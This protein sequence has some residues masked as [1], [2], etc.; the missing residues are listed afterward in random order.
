MLDMMIRNNALLARATTAAIIVWISWLLASGVLFYLEFGSTG[1]LAEAGARN[2]THLPTQPKPHVELSLLNLF[3][4]TLTESASTPVIDAPATRLNLELLGIFKA[5][6][7][8]QSAAIIARKGAEGE[9]FHPG[10]TL[11]GNAE[12]FDVLNDHVLIKR[13]GN[14]E[15]LLFDDNAYRSIPLAT[16]DDT[17][18]DTPASS[19]LNPSMGAPS[20]GRMDSGIDTG[21]TDAIDSS[22]GESLLDDLKERLALNPDA[23]LSEFGVNAVAEDAAS[24]YEI[25]SDAAGT[26]LQRSGLKEGDIILS[27]NG[28]PVGQVSSDLALLEQARKA[29]RLRIEVQRG[30]RKFFITVPVN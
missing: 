30:E 10:D 16:P 13:A 28:Q 7:K 14:M 17:E 3:G 1:T 8:T 22:T 6:E 21:N 29:R 15:K 26:L 23:V 19:F 12:L 11:P 20:A 24:G 9:I 4:Q 5:E 25:Q 18:A 27:V 2:S